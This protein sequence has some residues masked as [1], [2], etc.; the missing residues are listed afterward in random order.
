MRHFYFLKF[1]FSF[2]TQ[3]IEESC[4][5]IY[6]RLWRKGARKWR[7]LSATLFA[8][9]QFERV[10]LITYSWVNR[11]DGVSK[12]DTLTILSSKPTVEMTVC[13]FFLQGR[14]RYGEKCWNEHPRG[15]GGGGFRNNSYNRSAAQQQ[16]QQPRPGS[17]GGLD[18]NADE[19]SLLPWIVL[20]FWLS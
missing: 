9:F 17:G 12:F 14:C 19:A 1:I 20:V 8:H 18:I 3:L 16:Q 10:A 11:W 15:G 7:T 13:N 6:R 2:L 4:L 5:Y